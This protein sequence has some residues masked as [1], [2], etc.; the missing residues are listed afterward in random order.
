[1]SQDN[2]EILA[3]VGISYALD[4]Y[5]T[6]HAT[7]LEKKYEV[8]L[9]KLDK[10]F[11]LKTI[12][13]RR[14]I[15]TFPFEII[16]TGFILL[17][18]GAKVVVS[19]GQKPGLMVSVLTSFT[20][21]IIS[22]HWFTGQVWTK[23]SYFSLSFI[24]DFII[25]RLSN[26]LCCDGHSQKSFLENEL[27][28]NKEIHVPTHGTI[29]GVKNKFYY[30][31]NKNKNI[32]KTVVCFV[33]RITKDKG[34]EDLLK[35]ASFYDSKKFNGEVQFIIAG[36][37]DEYYKGYSDWKKK[38]SRINC[39]NLITNFVDPVSIFEKSDI[40]ILPSFR[41]GFGN[42]V[43]EA[44]AAGL[45][46]ISSDVYG[47]KDSFVDKSSG[48]Q[49][50][51]GNAKCFI[52]KVLKLHLDKKLMKEMQLNAVNFS[53]K[54]HEDFFRKDLKVVYNLIGVI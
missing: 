28:T 43:I 6:N 1:M 22:I 8:K 9:V 50:K 30:T 52:D 33:G 23:S 2:K 21:N 11:L 34:V 45:C 39:L 24:C 10:Y 19:V 26:H 25:S 18:I 49:C 20:K 3:L 51:A 14:S 36:P 48:Y 54:F 12:Y 46:I 47:L 40:L 41:E 53:K 44:Q 15:F 42:I 13:S 4:N 38:A 31:K 29:N 17:N 7:I 35:I 16:L 32:S 27:N 37:V 5:L